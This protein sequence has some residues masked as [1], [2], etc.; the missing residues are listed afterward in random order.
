LLTHILGWVS[1]AT[2]AINT[3]VGE[4]KLMPPAD[5]SCKVIN[6][7]NQQS[8]GNG[9]WVL[10]RAMRDFEYWMDK[11]VRDKVA[12]V[13]KSKFQFDVDQAKKRGE[14]PDKVEYPAHAGLVV[15]FWKFDVEKKDQLQRPGRDL[16]FWSG[17]AVTIVQLGVAAIPFGVYGNWGVFVV[18]VGATIL[19]LTTGFWKQ[20]GREKWACRQIP[21]GKKKTFIMVSAELDSATLILTMRTVSDSIL[22]FPTT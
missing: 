5:T 8:R 2:A 18:T 14:D 17:I 6:V 19:C 16:L 15:S 22:I 10:G 7:E 13:K 12:E 9:S 1:Y 11:P 4:N 21:P 20:W 3:A